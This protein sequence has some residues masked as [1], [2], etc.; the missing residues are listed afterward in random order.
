LNSET[1]TAVVSWVSIQHHEKGLRA[2]TATHGRCSERVKVREKREAWAR[3]H[4]IGLSGEVRESEQATV[5]MSGTRLLEHCARRLVT[6]RATC[7][8][9]KPVRSKAAV[10][11]A[12]CSQL[13]RWN[14]SAWG[15]EFDH[16]F[17]NER[18]RERCAR[19]CLRRCHRHLRAMQKPGWAHEKR[20][21][22]VGRAFLPL[23]VL[24]RFGTP[25]GHQPTS[26]FS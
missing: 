2:A 15:I 11:L 3:R 14:S 4:P 25:P 19:V 8:R 23:N 9:E 22:E 12:R 7:S 26:L 20:N 6:E 21:E 13:E 17:P 24:A 10:V 1:E 16:C 5:K 18:E